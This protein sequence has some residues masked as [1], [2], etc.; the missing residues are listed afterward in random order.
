MIGASHKGF[1]AFSLVP[2]EDT[3]TSNVIRIDSPWST[4]YVKMV[5]EDD[6]DA[7][8]ACQ[9][10]ISPDRDSWMD[11]GGAIT[12][13]TTTVASLHTST[14]TIPQAGYLRF[15]VGS[16]STSTGII[17]AWLSFINPGG[18]GQAYTYTSQ[19]AVT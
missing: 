17:D 12:G 5:V 19:P 2:G 4:P 11:H 13:G 14:W 10:Q 9:M 3:T 7:G 18:L 15:L 1:S 16:I 8:F 6:C